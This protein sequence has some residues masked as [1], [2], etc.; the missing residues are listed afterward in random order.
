MKILIAAAL[1]IYQCSSINTQN[2]LVYTRIDSDQEIAAFLADQAIL[3]RF[4]K[5]RATLVAVGSLRRSWKN[6][7]NHGKKTSFA[8]SIIIS[9]PL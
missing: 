6:N 3:A 1:S 7:S 2:G 9:H 4:V 5:S 8:L